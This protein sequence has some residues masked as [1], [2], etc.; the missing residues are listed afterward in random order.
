MKALT[1]AP[2]CRLVGSILLAGCTAHAVSAAPLATSYTQSFNQSAS[3]ADGLDLA[4]L[5]DTTIISQ[6]MV[7]DRLGTWTGTTLTLELAYGH[8]VSIFDPGVAAPP[9]A[10]RNLLQVDSQLALTGSLVGATALQQSFLNRW[11]CAAP[12]LQCSPNGVSSSKA[13]VLPELPAI[14]RPGDVLNGL[15]LQ[16]NTTSQVL[17]PGAALLSGSSGL[18]GRISLAG[19]YESKSILAYTADAL[20]ATAG[21]SA[22]SRGERLSA[23]TADIAALR[24]ADYGIPRFNSPLSAQAV[25]N[26]AALSDSQTLLAASADTAALLAAAA[27]PGQATFESRFSIPA[28]AWNLSALAAPALGRQATASASA[29]SAATPALE[30]A[31]LHAVLNSADDAGLLQSMEASL[32]RPLVSSSTPITSFAGGM[33]GLA[34][35]DISV[36]LSPDFGSG[37]FELDLQAADHHA[38]LRQGFYYDRLTLLSGG[39]ASGLRL[40]SEAAG[41]D[42]YAQAGT[43]FYLGENYSGMLQIHTGGAAARIALNNFYAPGLLLVASWGVAAVPEPETYAMLLAGLGLMGAVARKRQMGKSA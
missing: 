30:L 12:N 29:N 25:V 13:V 24:A 43:A 14:T 15:R 19:Q 7:N 33:I 42:D 18:S 21:T 20:A 10:N 16:L 17:T 35:A 8:T 3:F 23:A 2:V 36:Y 26:N 39:P 31:A 11:F 6:R 34:G 9:G 27:T 38:L 37:S 28:Q 32:G 41:I 4:L 22:T 1:L 5:T 40:V